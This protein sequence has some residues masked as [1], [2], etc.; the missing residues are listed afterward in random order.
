MHFV[1]VAI[2]IDDVVSIDVEKARALRT[3]SSSV[4]LINHASHDKFVWFL[5][6]KINYLNCLL[7]FTSFSYLQV[8][9]LI[10]AQAND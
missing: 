4:T 7:W 2:N 1:V 10:K 3:Q 6:W 9:Q 8:C 5:N